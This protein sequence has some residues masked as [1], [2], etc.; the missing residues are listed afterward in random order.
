LKIDTVLIQLIDEKREGLPL[1]SLKLSDQTLNLS[2]YKAKETPE[3][4]ILKKL[5]TH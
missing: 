1:I 4:Y 2:N 3:S 5:G